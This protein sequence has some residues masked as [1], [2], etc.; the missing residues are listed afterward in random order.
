LGLVVGLW[1]AGA[2]AQS[3]ADAEVP[4]DHDAAEESGESDG[5]ALPLRLT[6]RPL[7][8]P[9]GKVVVTSGLALGHMRSDLDIA[10]CVETISGLVCT[11]DSSNRSETTPETSAGVAVGVIDA[12]E[13]GLVPLRLREGTDGAG[14]AEN[15]LRDPLLYVQAAALRR[16]HLQL[17]FGYRVYLPFRPDTT[18]MTQAVSLD[19]LARSHF[20]RAE[21]STFVRF[22]SPVRRRTSLFVGER[23]ITPGVA[24]QMSG[25]ITDPFAIFFGFQSAF[26]DAQRE[27]HT[28]DVR[29]GLA[30]TVRRS[31]GEPLADIRVTFGALDVKREEEGRVAERCRTGDPGCGVVP[32]AAAPVK[33]YSF[34]LSAIFFFHDAW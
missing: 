16:E 19:L 1:A 30:G 15:P 26:F 9:R 14:E 18:M 2:S 6:E 7:T 29:A 22:D 17:G 25:Q 24:V 13:I 11:S 33:H 31:T 21:A 27:G 3:P 28:T 10:D 12:L 23:I 5:A 4:P 8:L 32:G 34:G 20:V